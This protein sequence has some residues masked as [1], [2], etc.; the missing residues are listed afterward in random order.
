MAT[1][2]TDLRVRPAA[3]RPTRRNE[4]VAIGMFALAA[5]LA[6]CL[7]SYNPDD[8]SWTAAADGRARNW[9]GSAG[10]NVAAALYQSFGLAALLLPLLLMA[11]GWRHFRTRRIH[12]PLTRVVGLAA[13]TLSAA[14]LCSLYVSDPLVDRSFNAGGVVGALI[15]EN[16]RGFFNTVGAT[17]VMAAAASVGLLLATNF[18]FVRAYERVAAALANPSGAF[19]RTVER[20]GAWREARAARRQASIELRREARAAREREEEE[21]RRVAEASLAAVEPASPVVRKRAA[22]AAEAGPS[23]VA[24][25]KRSATAAGS[26]GSASVRRRTHRSAGPSATKACLLRRRRLR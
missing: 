2:Q 21:S 13:L 26:R 8:P 23:A 14:A 11:A 25:L 3:G 7:A 12:A 20:V 16:L 6:L 5:L 10:A 15:A 17:V 22:A 4:I 24:A 19:R 9:V 18:S 1:T